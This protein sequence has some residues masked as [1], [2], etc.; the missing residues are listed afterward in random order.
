[1]ARSLPAGATAANTVIAWEPVWAIGTGDS[2][3][4]P[5]VLAMHRFL[6]QQL[7]TLLG[8]GVRLLYGGSVN[9]SNSRELLDIEQVD[10]LLIGGASLD[11]E[12]FWQIATDGAP[13]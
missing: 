6:K 3:N 8:D 5:D 2:A 13:D 10:G 11:P 7:M 4:V 9:P 1:M 12:R